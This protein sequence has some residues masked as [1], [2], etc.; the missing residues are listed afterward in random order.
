VLTA[1]GRQVLLSVAPAVGRHATP[2]VR[3]V[4]RRSAGFAKVRDEQAGGDG[5]PASALLTS[6]RIGAE[7]AAALKA[8]ARRRIASGT[9]FAHIAYMSLVAHKAA[10]RVVLVALPRTAQRRR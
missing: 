4:S 10:W 3:V 7:M 1:V 8:E 2:A 6:G 5:S 9:Y